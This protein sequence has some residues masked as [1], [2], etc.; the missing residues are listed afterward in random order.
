MANDD[1]YKQVYFYSEQNTEIVLH[2]ITHTI[3]SKLQ[4]RPLYDSGEV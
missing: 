1:R 3:K 2:T 4:A